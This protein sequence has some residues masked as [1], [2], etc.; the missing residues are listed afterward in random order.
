VATQ[1]FTSSMHPDG[2][3]HWV[4]MAGDG[5]DELRLGGGGAATTATAAW[6]G[7][8]RNALGAESTRNA[9]EDAVDHACA[10]EPGDH[11][12][13]IAAPAKRH[14]GDK[15]VARY[16]STGFRRYPVSMHSSELQKGS[17]QITLWRG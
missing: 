11:R 3:E 17:T 10:A 9:L 13:L 8:V 12:H 1:T 5:V 14:P 16:A 2:L 7:W 4:E 15:G 6:S